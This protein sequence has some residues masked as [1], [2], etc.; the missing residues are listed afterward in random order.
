[1]PRTRIRNR[2]FRIVIA[3]LMCLP[4]LG[5]GPCVILVENAMIRGFFNA[6]TRL[7]VAQARDHLGLTGH[8]GGG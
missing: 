8:D 6:A 5:T 1:M 2:R 4:L 3:A 7:L